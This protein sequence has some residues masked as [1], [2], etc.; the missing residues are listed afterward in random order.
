MTD[1]DKLLRELTSSARSA[2]IPQIDVRARVIA[3]L[4]DGPRPVSLDPIPI[5][6]V[7]FALTTAA[8]VLKAFW[9]A[10]QALSEPWIVYLT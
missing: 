3:T 4:A 2:P 10:W 6:F 1:V 9:P 7:G 5:A 8:A